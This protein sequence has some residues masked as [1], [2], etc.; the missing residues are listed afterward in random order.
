ML[1]HRNLDRLPSFKNAVVTIGTFDGVHSGHRQII[2]Q[3]NAEAEKCQGESVII[4][5]DPHPRQVLSP[6]NKPLH[7][8]TT[9]EEKIF[10]LEKQQ[11]DHLVI[12]PFTRAFSEL[13]ASA[14]IADFLVSKFQPHTIIIGYD[15][16]FGH[17]REGNIQLLR[18]V[19][20]QYHFRVVEIPRQVVHD[21]TVS[22]T[23]IREHLMAGNV[24]VANELLGYPYFISG[25]VV[26]GDKR[27]REL[28]FPTA[29]IVPADPQ[30]LIPAEGVYAASIHIPSPAACPGGEQ[31]GKKAS[32]VLSFGGAANIGRIPTFQGKEQRVE[33]YIFNFDKDIY[34][35]KIRLSFYDYIRPDIRF[36]NAEALVARMQEDV[37][38]IKQILEKK[39]GQSKA[40]KQNSQ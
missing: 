27:G 1:V 25:V 26:H 13:S 6:H 11:V 38:E 40:Q 21:L 34:D 31:A 29:N 20:S 39:G 4:T 10:L 24:K 33:V 23:K 7:L 19:Q 8:L 15:H 22:S 18:R 36:D 2:K 16:H 5:F 12:V 9:L 37:K 28:G 30:K 35:Q 14:Y 3:L 32:G 17:N